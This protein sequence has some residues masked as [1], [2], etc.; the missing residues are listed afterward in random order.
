M[1]VIFE[2]VFLEVGLHEIWVRMADLL[3]FDHQFFLDWLSE[4][5][6]VGS[7]VIVDED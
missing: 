7:V 6:C 2:E 4:I 3:V 1:G 5:S